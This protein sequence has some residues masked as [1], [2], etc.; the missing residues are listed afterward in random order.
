MA[1]FDKP[2]YDLLV[3]PEISSYSDLKGKRF[4]VG[5]LSGFSFEIPRAM[6]NRNGLEFR[7][8]VATLMIGPTA[9]RLLALKANA[10]QATLLDPP[11]NFL[12]V[13]EGLHKLDSSMS[14]FQS[15][16][17]AL[18]TSEQKI[19]SEPDD[20]RRFIRARSLRS[21]TCVLSKSTLSNPWF[22]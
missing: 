16:L 22:D 13:Q 10:V 11:Y 7:R 18:M 5:S 12:A 4:A 6:L 19:R 3:R 14:Y 2:L 21:R 17:G 9:D 20:V 8:D 1:Y 15:L